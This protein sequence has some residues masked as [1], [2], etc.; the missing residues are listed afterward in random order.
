MC[1]QQYFFDYVLGYRSPSNKKAD[2]GT[3]VHKV[4]EILAFVKFT[5]Q[6]NETHFTDDILGEID[7]N[8]YDLDDL[9][10]RVYDYYTS[11]FKHHEW[12][13]KDRRD[14]T[15]WTYKAI[16]Y[17]DGMFDPRNKN[18]LYPE[19]QFDIL[20]DKPWAEYDY[21]DLKGKLAIK[22]TIDLITK[23]ND[24]T[25]E[26]IDW[27]TGRR[28][29]WA[30]G[31]EK[32]QAKLEKDPQL[33]LYFY[34]AQ[35]LYPEIKHCIVTIFFINDGGP[36][37]MTFDSKDIYA[38]ERLLRKKFEDIKKCKKPKL[39]KSWKCTKLC[40]YGNNHFQEAHVTPTIEYRD[41]QICSKDTF[42]TMCEQVKHDIELKGMDAVVDEYTMPGYNVGYYKAPGSTE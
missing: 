14:C 35:K 15:N 25:L 40:H 34:A 10:N 16:N 36:F 33:M 5:Q 37:S 20:I 28:L 38:T 24:D 7:V 1:E 32:T 11:N 19:Q 8:N 30:T 4:L 9:C 26:I 31:E 2:K 41:N 18:I 29:N 39:S 22:G 23:A 12:S 6:K 17:G 13:E 42:M 3:I 21:G 27:K